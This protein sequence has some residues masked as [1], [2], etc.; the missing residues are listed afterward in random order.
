[1]ISDHST[2]WHKHKLEL[3]LEDETFK[4]LLYFEIQTDHRVPATRLELVLINKKKKTCQLMDLAVPACEKKAK[5]LIVV[6]SQRVKST[7]ENDGD[8]DIVV[9]VNKLRTVP[10][11]W[12]KD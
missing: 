2:I 8:G 1:M 6:F 5:S 7:M 4:I 10:K 12:K 9:I 11:S 3:A